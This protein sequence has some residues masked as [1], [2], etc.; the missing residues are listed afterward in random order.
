MSPS[1]EIPY[2]HAIR[3]A[4]AGELRRDERVV[5]FGEDVGAYGG[6][7]G[8][9]RGLRE[10]FGDRV[11]DTP[12]SEN[13]IVGMAVG[14]A[15][16]G[17][18]PVAELQYSDF[19]FCAG[20]E[21]FLKAATWRYAHD[22]ACALPM[23][24]RMAS[25]GG[26]FGPEHSQCTEAYLM[27]TPGLRVAV[28]ST[29][30]D[31][32]GVTTAAIRSEEPVFVFEHK[33]LYGTRGPV[34]EGEHVVE[35]GR[36]TVRRPGR[37][38][39]VVA[40]QDMLRRVLVAAERLAADGIEL[41]VVDPVTLDPFD[42]ETLLSS[43]ARTGACMVVEEAPRTLG[44]G[45]EIGALLMEHAFAHLD[46]PLVRLGIPD[47]PVPTAQHLVDALVPSVND[48]EAAVRELLA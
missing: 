6:V 3:E 28:P 38:L 8:A 47:V 25:G 36:A 18:R 42:A 13:L 37:H 7:W 5:V 14:M 21:V 19:V 39:T 26:G 41:E 1:R 44:V 9:L 45:A 17:L 34:P 12:I 16:R 10:E 48:V 46:R 30:A 11:F 23:V 43:V 40:W 24:V 33:L 31:A 32:K 29:P 20:D 27:H 2:A 4:L 22:G 35:L 15:M